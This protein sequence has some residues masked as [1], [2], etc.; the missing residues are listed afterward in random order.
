LV[1]L[2]DLHGVQSGTERNNFWLLV[3]HDNHL[4]SKWQGWAGLWSHVVVIP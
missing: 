2:H 4:L 3:F 1:F